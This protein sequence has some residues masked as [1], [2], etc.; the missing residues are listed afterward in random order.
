M[1]IVE[2][3]ENCVNF[4]LVVESEKFEKT[5]RKSE[6]RKAKSHCKNL[7]TRNPLPGLNGVSSCPGPATDNANCKLWVQP[8]SPH[9][10]Y[11]RERQRGREADNLIP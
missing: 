5:N 7:C 1:H 9:L 8:D 6:K 2:W 4:I 11:K 10:F 3:T